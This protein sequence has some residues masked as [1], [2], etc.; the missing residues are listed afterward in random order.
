MSPPKDEPANLREWKTQV[1]KE[2]RMARIT[3]MSRETMIL[4]N[5]RLI[6]PGEIRDGFEVTVEDGRITAIGKRSGAEVIDLDGN[7]LAPGFIDLHIHGGAA[8]DTMEASEEAFRAIC[9]Y[10]AGGG[11]K[12]LLL[13]TVSAPI[14]KI[15]DVLRAVRDSKAI[16]QIAGVHIEGP[17]ISRTRCGAQGEAFIRNPD[18]DSVG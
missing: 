9:D 15:V 3:R 7:Y 5:A 10:H 17:F 1:N 16:R 18:Q 12:S 13:T 6:S 11:T 8:H 4:G 14:P 2:P